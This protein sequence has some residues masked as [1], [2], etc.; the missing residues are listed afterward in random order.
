M[1]KILK[2]L[3]FSLSTIIIFVAAV[4]I[5]FFYMLTPKQFT[6][7]VNKYCTKYLDAK[8]NFNSVKVSVFEEFPKLNVKLVG[9]EII[10][11]AM[12]TDTSYLSLHHENADTLMR[13][14]ELIVSLNLKDLLKSN[15]N[16]HDISVS[17]PIINAY[18]SHSGRANWEIYTPNKRNDT[19]DAKKLALNINTFSIEGPAKLVYRASPD[20]INLRASIGNLFFKGNIT[21][22]TAKLEIS[23]F[24]LSDVKLNAEI[25]KNEIT[26][27][28]LLDSTVIEAGE[29]R[30]E[31]N[32]KI[33]GAASASVKKEK[34]CDSLPLKI[35]AT[36]KLAPENLYFFG[37]ENIA[38]TIADL[39]QLKLDGELAISKDDIK[40]DLECKISELPVQSLLSLV[41]ERFSVETKK[42]LTNIKIELNAKIS[43]SY[44]FAK[45]GKRPNVTA[46]FK[47]PKGYVIYKDTD[48]KI[49]NIF[50][51]ASLRFDNDNPKNTGIKIKNID[52]EAFAANL[53]GSV[54]A[55]NIL[56]DPN[57]TMKLNGF[58]DL[59]ELLKF[60]P[61]DLGI[62]ARGN[63]LFNIDGSIRVSR[64]NERDW[65]KN[66]FVAQVTADKIRVRFPKDS[67]GIL[68]E[69]T[70]LE[71]NTTK[72]RISRNTGEVRRQISVDFKSDTA[73]IRMPSRETIA[74]S[75]V[76]LSMRS[77]DAI[78]SGDTSRVIPMTGSVTANTLQYTDVDSSTISLRELKTNI[79][80]RSSAENRTLPLIRFDVETKQL[81]M[82]SEENRFGVRDASIAITA[83]K[84]DPNQRRRQMTPEQLDSLQ[85]I[86]PDIQ[87]DSL[88][89]HARRLRRESRES[90]EFAEQDINIKNAELGTLLRS[91]TV[92][93]NIKSLTGRIVSPHFPLRTRLQNIDASFT[94]NDVTLKNVTV[95]CG[96]SKFDINAKVEGIR[97]AL[98]SGRGLKIEA[99]LK[100]DTINLDELLTAAYGASAYSETSNEY[101]KAVA[102]A[103]DDEQLEKIIQKETEDEK[104]IQKLIV[105]PSNV[106]IDTKIDVSYGKY[107]GITLEKLSGALIS[108]DRCLQLKD[109]VAK[110]SVGEIDLT[111]LYATRGKED[112]TLGIDLEFKDIQV[113][114]FIKII[115]SIDSLAPML[116]SFKGVINSQIAATVSMD[117]TMKIILQTLNAACRIS[118]KNMILLDGETFSEISKTLK[119]KNR[120]ENFVESI[121]LEMLAHDNQIEIFPFIMQID[122]YKT[123]ISGVQRLDMTFNYHISVLKSQLPFMM[124]INISGNI[125]NMDKMKIRLSK[126]KY[127]DI[128]LPTYVTLIDTT[129]L[130]LRGQIDNFL[131]QGVDVA[132]FSQFVAPTLDSSLIEKDANILTK[133]DSLALLKE[134]IIVIAPEK[135]PDAL[136]ANKEKS[137]QKRDDKKRKN[138]RQNNYE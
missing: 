88:A 79:R 49:D 1:K 100:A 37:L 27:E 76:D 14:N 70:N 54:N 116:Q 96:E 66:N 103:Q 105:I 50:V 74:I 112:I 134:G 29:N 98:S 41:P 115:P 108:R 113:E 61:E 67:I 106:S 99:N 19:N 31:Y 40:S 128:N 123:A 138:E 2:P 43:G 47:I 45:N 13:F 80:I 135:T 30:R 118:G 6:P 12:Q 109:I 64:L 18:V 26:A 11:N 42:Y 120:E 136:P 22:D 8:V 7:I 73:R 3:I 111:A 68:V 48:A 20:S 28:L 21:P 82:R 9:G 125:E 117:S 132:R 77:S 46:D 39:P 63:V 122:R 114:D 69:K 36:L 104:E 93:G 35:N 81:G 102:N 85:T 127:K 32:L 56:K 87:R 58:A 75:K 137:R 23:K 59:K 17:Q 5:L 94:T 121:S 4:V 78:L 83:T 55:T 71:L 44:E 89:Q 51:D 91:W 60:A 16:I 62:T 53:K 110:T 92:D 84:N 15:I 24:V 133:E 34:Y 119:F 129:R 101:K 38:L 107:G 97:R 52:I 86:Y 25:E 65:A 126:P 95:R 124:G 90:D 33:E 130:N 72:T 131:R 57:V 10:S